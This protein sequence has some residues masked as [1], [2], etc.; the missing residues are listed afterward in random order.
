MS[1]IGILHNLLTN[2]LTTEEY[3]K[4]DRLATRHPYIRK[5]RGNTQYCEL[6]EKSL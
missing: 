1:F 2:I 3:K 4:S 5:A 6:I